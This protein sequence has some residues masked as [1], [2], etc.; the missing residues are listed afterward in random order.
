[1]LR[2]DGK[3][4]I[5]SLFNSNF[6]IYFPLLINLKY[7]YQH[8]LFLSPKLRLIYLPLV[9]NFVFC[10]LGSQCRYLIFF[11]YLLTPGYIFELEKHWQSHLVFCCFRFLSLKWQ[12]V[13]LKSH[14]WSALPLFI[15]SKAASERWQAAGY[16]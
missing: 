3:L 5:F 8:F 6:T 13:K 15:L 12:Q 1:M 16:L 14:P 11:N 7:L 4:L 9:F 10:S 2:Y